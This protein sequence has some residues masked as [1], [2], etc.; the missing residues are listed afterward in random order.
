MYHYTSWFQSS[1][2][3]YTKKSLKNKIL[4]LQKNLRSYD[5]VNAIRKS[6]I[7]IRLIQLSSSIYEKQFEFS[8]SYDEAATSINRPRFNSPQKRHAYP[9]NAISLS[10][11]YMH[12]ALKL[13]LIIIRC[14]F[15]G[16]MHTYI[17]THQANDIRHSLSSLRITCKRAHWLCIYENTQSYIYMYTAFTHW[18]R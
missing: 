12:I 7:F 6:Y 17:Y 13:P 11:I 2:V 18:S 4:L 1:K 16:A 3:Y 9:Q 8:H 5:F 14:K 15:L 10:W